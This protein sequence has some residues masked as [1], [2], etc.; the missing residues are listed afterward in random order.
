[1]N[2]PILLL[3]TLATLA[4][5]QSS[6][7]SPLRPPAIPLAVRSPYMSTWQRAGS[8]GG[9]GGYLAGQWPT[10]WPGQVT[11]WTGMIRVDNSTYT[12]MGAPKDVPELVTQT[13]F[14]YTSTRSI[15]T[16]TAGPVQMKITFLSN[17]TPD[18]LQRSSLP[19]SYMDVEVHSLDDGE[20]S[21]Q[22]YS[23]ISAEWVSGDRGA[24]AE[25]SYGDIGTDP[26][27]SYHKVFRQQQLEFAQVDDQAEWGN[28]YF[29]TANTAGVTFQS[30]SDV[31]VRGGFIDNGI[32]SNT[33]DTNY[34]PIN[35]DYPVF[36]Y[37]RDFG[38]VGS[39]T[40]DILFQLSLHQE[41]CMQ[42]QG[43]KDT[44]AKVPC[45]WNSY[46][47]NETEAVAHFYNDYSDAK[48]LASD[49]DSK[50]SKD[51]EAAGGSDY[52]SLTTLA[53]RQ[54]FGAIEFTNNPT[55]ILVFMKE[56]SSN[57]NINTVDV[58][59]P[60]HPIALYT[61][62]NILKWLLDPL[63]INQESGNWPNTYSIH[64]IGASFPNAT[65]HSDGNA[66]SMPLEECGNMLIMTLAYAQRSK[67]TDYLA[68]HYDI[69]KQWTGYLV[70]EALIPAEQ[71]STDDFA[72]PAVNQ[73]NLALKGI[74]G[75]SAMAQI[76]TLTSHSADADNYTSIAS[77]YISQWQDLAIS[78]DA[79][80]PHATFQYGN[81]S[82]Y[83]L[84]YNLYADEELGL[85]LVPKEVYDLQSEFYPTKFEQYGVPLDTRHPAGYTKDDWQLFCAAVASK[86]TKDM[87]TKTIAKW[88]GET[89]TSLAMGDL[90]ETVSG[91]YPAGLQFAARPVAGGYFA[92]LAL[93]SAP[94]E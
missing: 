64:D 65:G 17:V 45:L 39:E 85:G 46:F 19:Y 77:S 24:V 51:S 91:D 41:N 86:D 57:G 40:Q 67:D 50:V 1:M 59:F 25:W 12:W 42:F 84:L 89:L 3:C 88:L 36:G 7:F 75:I 69:L 63:Y 78:K 15:F 38:K 55:D 54:A 34:R 62:P 14:E 52:A 68:K 20:H 18:D 35:Q 30:G 92:F 58:I 48:S 71:I 93:D 74:I 76:A 72:G 47:A 23:D 6:T 79:S 43:Q 11:G 49:F 8:D 87:F 56:I 21:V 83:S 16:M 60:F 28:W 90:H 29:A 37:A 82:S 27:I 32:L 70:D 61:N 33:K 26:A 44:V 9:N 5:G 13:A 53:A 22:I 81:E 66:E 2:L 80:P 94:S 10:F 31:D 4:A 73:T